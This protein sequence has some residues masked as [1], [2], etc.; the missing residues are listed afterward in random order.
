MRFLHA[1][2]GIAVL[3]SVPLEVA[4]CAHVNP[5]QVVL[6]CAMDA[7]K[8][9]Q[10]IDAVIKA[11]HAADPEAALVTLIASLGP[12]GEELVV[13]IVESLVTNPT[14]SADPTV[15]RNGRTFLSKRGYAV[16]K[17]SS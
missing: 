14:P 3:G 1:F 11:L 13:C 4:S 5:G 15:I 6:S 17:G 7:A 2:I 8:D 10:T 9:P 16:P 12:V